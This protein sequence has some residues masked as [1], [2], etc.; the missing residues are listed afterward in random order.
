MCSYSYLDHSFVEQGN[1][2]LCRRIY[3]LV[4]KHGDKQYYLVHYFSDK[5]SSD[6]A[7]DKFQDSPKEIF[8]TT[9]TPFS[10]NSTSDE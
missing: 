3:K 10:N 7:S 6:I 2:P 1:T 5:T 8:S 9:E 4:N